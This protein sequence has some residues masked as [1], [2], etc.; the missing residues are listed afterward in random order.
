MKALPI[1]FAAF[2]CLC[3]ASC[4][5]V[6]AVPPLSNKP[7]SGKAV[8]HHDARFIEPGKTTKAEVIRNLGSGY[9]D[10]IRV[11]AIAYPWEMPGGTWLSWGL[12]YIPIAE[13]S[14]GGSASGDLTRWRALFIAFDARGVVT[15]KEFMRLKAKRSLDEQLEAWAG[16]LPKITP[17]VF[18]P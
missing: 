9:R 15:R 10:S 8:P 17:P 2:G 16:W 13:W 12:F 14:S 6:V 11:P 3:F 5:G 4:V 1:V 7:I 18:L